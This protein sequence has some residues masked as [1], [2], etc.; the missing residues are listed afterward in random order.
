VNDFL[1]WLG[2]ICLASGLVKHGFDKLKGTWR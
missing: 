1:F 2:V